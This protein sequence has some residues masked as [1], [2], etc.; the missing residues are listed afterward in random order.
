MS[1]YLDTHI[2]VRLADGDLDKL[3]P[4]AMQ[5]IART[6]LLLS[7][8]VLVEL[9]YLFELNKI[10]LSADDVR[11]KLEFELGVR[12]CQFSFQAIADVA[13]REKWT[14][15][16][17]D[18]IIVAHARV[19]GISSLISADRLIRQNYPRAVW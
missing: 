15:D 8:M 18:R 9:E 10:R 11:R 1:A 5:T 16:P 4:T 13:F 6:D 19:N 17:F 2:A 7:P 12:V 3:S 14:R